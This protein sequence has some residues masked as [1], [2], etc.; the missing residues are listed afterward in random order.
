MRAI[1]CGDG[2]ALFSKNADF[3]PSRPLPEGEVGI[4]I[5][6]TEANPV[7]IHS[8]DGYPTE[9]S[10]CNWI[11]RFSSTAYSIG[12]SLTSGSIKPL[13]IMVLA[14][15]SVSPRLMR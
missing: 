8:N 11:N 7:A 1:R 14:S 2:N 5:S 3:E 12:S 9:P 10:I 4:T 6:A 13:T 15:A